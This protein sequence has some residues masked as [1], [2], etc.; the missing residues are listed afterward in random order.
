MMNLKRKSPGFVRT[1]GLVKTLG[2]VS[3]LALS[4]AFTGCSDDDDNPMT[5]MGEGA[6]LRVVHAS[7][8][9]GNV[10]IYAEGV[11]APL[12]TNV[13]YTATSAY[14]DLAP[15][16]YNIQLRAAGAAASSTPV[17]ETGMVT[18]PE[19]AR[20]TA[21]AAGLAG[22]SNA[23][24][25][26]RVL[27]MAESFAAPG[28]GNAIVRVVHASADAPTVA[29]DVGNDGTPEIASLARFADTG[30]AG[31]AL[32][33]GS[34]LALGIW[35]A[36]PLS[37]VTS[38]TT[39]ALPAGAEIFVI[40]TGLV[41]ELPRAADGFGLL[42]VGPAGTIGLIRQDPT[43]FVLHASPDAPEVDVNLGGT[44]TTLVNDLAFGELS[45]PLQ[46]APGAYTL[47]VRVAAGGAF[48][49]AYTTPS[50]AAGE[51]YLAIASGYAADPARAFTVVPFGET[52]GEAV[53]A[54]VR[55][56]HA[57]PDAPAVNVGVLN[58]ASITPVADFS[59]LAFGQAS[60]AA[61]TALAAGA[62]TVGVAGAGTT[63]PVVA[64]FDL[65]LT[66]GL[67]AFAV[68]GG[69]L[70]ASG[71]TFRLLVVDATSFPW[72]VAT[73]LPN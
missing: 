63:T 53:G 3:M 31:V 67:R 47:D 44:A 68:A 20:I 34:P 6:E 33:A 52:F 21:I 27:L 64:S 69:S 11:A 71:E 43:V 40:A 19:G 42:A 54:R 5:P 7:P 73:V 2:L 39:P 48:V 26:L 37:K 56:V 14:L 4:V 36:S 62:L 46:V 13:P 55:V 17:F 72:Q 25:K 12:L 23:A 16:Q 60:S 58:G 22:S 15:G 50:L 45:A 18:V 65:G 10:D 8:D 35:V 32:P 70:A 61:G 24:D 49:A 30:A 41:G 38:L 9:A 28:A 57:S 66:A 29:V 51:R 1:L 59:N